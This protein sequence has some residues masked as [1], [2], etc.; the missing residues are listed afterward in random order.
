MFGGALNRLLGSVDVSE[1]GNAITILGMPGEGFGKQVTHEWGTSKVL[2]NMF[3]QVTPYK[4][5]FNKF[6]AI[7]VLY[8]LEELAKKKTAHVNRRGLEK[9]I[10]EL[11]NNTWLKDI[12]SMNPDILNLNKTGLFIKTPKDHQQRFLE[13]YNKMVP[14]YN[15]N[16]YMLAAKPGAGKTLTGLMLGE[17]LSSD[18]FVIISP[19]NA[20]RKVW[21]KT[22]KEEYKKPYT[23][24]DIWVSADERP[25]ERGKRFYIFHYE[26]MA[27][28]KDLVSMVSGRRLIV[29]VDE[30]HNFNDPKSQR[31]QFLID[32]VLRS[33]CKHT[34]WSS[35]TPVKALGYEMI[36]CLSTIDPY[37]DS[38]TED[39][40]RKIFGKSV[41]KAVDIL[42]NRI[43]L[44]SFKVPKEEFTENEP[45][46]HTVNVKIPDPTRFTLAQV[47]KDMADFIS[48]QMKHYDENF[49]AYEKQYNAGVTYYDNLR[50]TGD[51]R[52]ELATY[53]QYIT[54]IRKQY[55]PVAMKNEVMFCN[56][57]ER[58]S[59]MPS[60]P[61]PLRNQFKNAR[62]VV[63]YLALKVQG[64]ALGRV[65]GKR[66]AECN[67]ALVEHAR[68]PG[69]IDGAEKKTIIFTSFVD[70][71]E[72]VFAY[73]TKQGYKPVI[74]HQ[75]T[76]KNLTS[77]IDS[78]GRDE[79][80]NPCVATF[81]SLS[82]AV[83]MVMANTAV[84]MNQPFREF[85]REQAIG[86]IDRL[87][88]D[89]QTYVFNVLLD[90]GGEAN[91]STR[92][93]DI[94][95]W[96]REQ[97]AAIMGTKVVDETAVSMESY[98]DAVAEDW[99]SSSFLNDHGI[100]VAAESLEELAELTAD[101]FDIGDQ[102]IP[103][104]TSERP[105]SS[106]W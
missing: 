54:M 2:N 106:V 8:M 45:I 57:V 89:T 61:Q 98:A 105:R 13:H 50:L 74:V 69:I 86:R 76:N 51:Q 72:A 40:F 34:I 35:G 5:S 56:N 102:W 85:E 53:R 16:G 70:V 71:A 1:A 94:V 73:V 66:R 68:L 7:D 15:L 84:L 22:I 10:E 29:I 101:E 43:G 93:A 90:T 42:R 80:V 79:D 11:Q 47:R 3:N 100:Y 58:R 67:A 48:A 4:L 41:S 92:A 52:K 21:E 83:P 95:Q 23:D 87:G 14:A 59:I 49:A 37:F 78:F 81:Q 96:S 91:I 99:V 30:S 19:M 63:K 17:C 27:K 9:A 104:N 25:L 46:E 44:V 55:D 38:N 6:F 103:L 65:L 39:R 20:V 24:K 18:V 64:E 36:P 28:L 88:Q 97:V 62:S 33:R 12:T 60:L 31:T 77:I 26:S 82:T 75:G 32:F